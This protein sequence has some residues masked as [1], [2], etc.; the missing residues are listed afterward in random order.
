MATTFKQIMK[1][2][3]YLLI[4]ISSVGILL[5]AQVGINTQNPQGVFHIDGA[6]DNTTS[7]FSKYA[8]DVIVTPDG[9]MGI[10]TITPQARLDLKGSLRIA[11]GNESEGY[12]FTDQDAA[13]KGKW[14][15]PN[16]SAKVGEWTLS[17]TSLDCYASY[18]EI[19]LYDS[20]TSAPS[21]LDNSQIALSATDNTYLTIPA[22]KYLIFI[23]QDIGYAEYGIFRI[24]NASSGSMIYLQYY[25]EW[26][27]GACLLLNIS[28]PLKIYVTWQPYNKDMNAL[29]NGYYSKVG[30]FP[31][32]YYLNFCTLT[33]LSLI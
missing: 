4:G 11:D 22:G 33:F 27:A 13:G 19:T 16:L 31:G 30:A 5:H 17:N 15:T 20:Q 25:A 6:G 2:K 32:R 3:F 26:L 7:S 29:S 10:G 12:V 8:N 14:M 1:K 28:A 21:Y 23:N 9:K 18:D 24:R